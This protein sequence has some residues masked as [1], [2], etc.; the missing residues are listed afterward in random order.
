MYSITQNY[1]ISCNIKHSYGISKEFLITSMQGLFNIFT[2]PTFLFS[3]VQVLFIVDAHFHIV[4]YILFLPGWFTARLCRSP[5]ANHAIL[6]KN[7]LCK[8]QIMLYRK[9]SV[10][11][12]TFSMTSWKCLEY[13]IKTKYSKK[14]QKRKNVKVPINFY[15]KFNEI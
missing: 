5:Y 8:S 7:P 4:S 10:K 2:L 6:P 11:W 9:F 12:A 14:T 3:I 1:E 15:G 13:T